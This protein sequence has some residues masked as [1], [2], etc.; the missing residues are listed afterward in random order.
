MHYMDNTYQTKLYE[1]IHNMTHLM[2]TFEVTKRCGYST[3]ITIY[4]EET[5][6]DMYAKVIDHFSLNDLMELFFY[7]PSGERIRVPLCK[8]SVGE[9]VQTNTS[10]NVNNLV[11]VY[12]FPRPVVYRLYIK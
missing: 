1:H 12:P 6:I 2:Y 7:T 8:Q 3:F 5:L 11:P 4:R 10:T 9:F